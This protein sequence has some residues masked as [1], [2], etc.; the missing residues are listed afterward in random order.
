MNYELLIVNCEL[1]KN[2][3]ADEAN[4]GYLCPLL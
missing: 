4:I 1:S 3:L 2:K